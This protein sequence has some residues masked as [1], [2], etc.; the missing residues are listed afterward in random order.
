MPDDN[1]SVL[2]T[3]PSTECAPAQRVLRT[4]HMK[5][6]QEGL[7]ALYEMGKQRA[8]L[9]LDVLVVQSVMAGLYISMGCNFLLSVGGD[10][11]GAA[12]F[13]AGLIAVTLTGAEL[14]TG[15]VLIFTLGYLAGHVPAKSVL[16]NWAI[17]WIGN[18]AGTLLW[19]YFLAYQSDALEVADR[20]S[21]AIANAER[22]TEAE[23]I[24]IFL[25]GIAANFMVCLGFWQATLADDVTGKIFGLWFPI[26]GFAA[27]GFDHV[28]ANQFFLSI[29][30]ML[31]ADITIGRYAAAL[32]IATFGNIVGGGFIVGAA[33]WYAYDKRSTGQSGQGKSGGSS[34]TTTPDTTH[35]SEDIEVSY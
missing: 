24:E 17:G 2:S 13:P 29:G 18:W 33:L 12:V 1:A 27:I 9:S 25:K 3:T 21:F 30:M 5:S 11:L 26:A 4:S 19:S 8:S 32:S 16:R 7:Q 10:F 31:G 28:I 23:L 34:G 6:T 14:F 20:V 35:G 15:D 22:R